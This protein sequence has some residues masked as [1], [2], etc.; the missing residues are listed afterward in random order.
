MATASS[1]PKPRRS[2]APR[3][4][5]MSDPRLLAAQPR[6]SRKAWALIGLL[7]CGCSAT[8]GDNHPPG[9]TIGPDGKPITGGEVGGDSTTP[10]G[11][12]CTIPAAVP[13][14]IVRLDYN[15]LSSSLTSLLGP[16]ALKGVVMPANVGNVRQRDFQALF[17]EGS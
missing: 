14:R 8:I 10:G 2:R 12:A 16:S 17:T 11:K 13:Q 7:V 5:S 3:R 9:K 6:W 1:G 4:T 15:K